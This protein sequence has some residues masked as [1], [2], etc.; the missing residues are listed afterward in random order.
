MA[1]PTIGQILEVEFVPGSGVYVDISSRTTSVTIS[2]PRSKPE[3]QVDAQPTVLTAVIRNHPDSSGYSPMTPGS[4]TAAYHPHLTRDRMVRFKVT[5][6]ASTYVRFWGWSDVWKPDVVDGDPSGSTVTLTASCVLSRYARRKL[7]SVFGESVTAV[8]TWPG[9]EYFPFDEP[10]DST[11][12]RGISSDGVDVLPGRVIMP[13][14]N[15]GS[16]TFSSPSGGHLTDGEIEFTRGDDNAPAPVILIKTRPGSLLR[17]FQASFKLS[18]DPAGSLGDD[19]VAGYNSKGQRLFVWSVKV[20]AGLVTWSLYD[21]AGT[22]QTFYNTGAPRDDAW[23]YWEVSFL[24]AGS[25]AGLFEKGGFSTVAGSF[26]WPYD[27]RRVAYLVLGGQMPPNRPGKQSNTFQGGISSFLIQYTTSPAFNFAE[28][29]VPNYT[30]DAGRAAGFINVANDDLD[31]L[32]GGA[33][34]TIGSLTD[35]TLVSYTNA[36]SDALDRW[37]EHARTVGGQLSTRPD[38]RREYRRAVDARPSTVSL[39]LDAVLDLD[40][41]SGSWEQTV[42]ERPTRVTATYPLGTATVI[43]TATE[44]LTGIKLEGPTVSVGA[45]SAAVAES[46]AA[47][48]MASSG[49]RLSS[50]GVSASLTSTDKTAALFGLNPGDRVRISNLNPTFAGVTYRDVFASGWTET[51]TGAYGLAQFQFDTDPADDPP[52]GVFDSATYGRMGMDPG[53]T[54]TG[55]TCVGTTGTGTVII[56]TTSPLTNVGAEFPMDLDWNGE[57]ITVSGVGGT[58]SPQT[59]TVTARG[60]APSV[61]RVH[62]AGQAVDVYHAATHTY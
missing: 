49:D 10:A 46:A 18:N 35:E 7:L 53:S 20:V 11:V 36:T 44:A 57:R 59:V 2:R 28:F 43:D 29:A 48:V 41:P 30:T 58:T 38:G 45:G 23:H 33:V 62:A 9:Q 4:P 12:V 50:F 61:A 52:E 5:V 34:D 6:G 21:D 55:G 26:V 31:T 42:E 24:P 40:F 19:M 16:L 39:T 37:N 15:H 17:M 27:P 8:P 60:V 51:Y 32:V 25:G 1:W 54:I 56:T 3:A 14:R 13:S 22:S 47:M